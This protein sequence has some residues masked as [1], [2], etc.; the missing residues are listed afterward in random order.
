MHTSITKI[1]QKKII[2][3]CFRYNVPEDD[4]V[5]F[6]FLAL[7]GRKTT[8]ELEEWF[9]EE[10]YK[11]TKAKSR[12]PNEVLS[13]RYLNQAPDY[14]LKLM[15]EF[16]ETGGTEEGRVI[17]KLAWPRYRTS[18]LQQDVLKYFFP[19]VIN[20]VRRVTHHHHHE[21]Q[22]QREE[23][24]VPLE[25]YQICLENAN[26]RF[27]AHVMFDAVLTSQDPTDDE[28]K[29]QQARHGLTKQHLTPLEQRLAGS[30]AAASS[31]L[32]QM[33]YMESR[34][35]RMRHTADSINS[36]IRY[37]SYLSVVVLLSVT[38][39]QVTYLK[40]YFRKKKLL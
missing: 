34:E 33:K 6:I 40:R 22:L 37:L 11:L 29:Q 16:H 2:Q 20:H 35:R 14:L 3:Q 4:D 38:Y 8:P 32:H 30:I 5:H 36:R 26:E 1:F 27:P 10:T 9:S 28:F 23:G 18:P 25:G 13:N 39:L 31:V 19:T 12:G 24:G 21:T 7:P 15:D 17:Y